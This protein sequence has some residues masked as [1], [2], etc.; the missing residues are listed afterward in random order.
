MVIFRRLKMRRRIYKLMATSDEVQSEG[1]PSEDWSMGRRSIIKKRGRSRFEY[2]HA[3]REE[4]RRKRP[5][6]IIGAVI[7]VLLAGVIGYAYISAFVIPPRNVILRVGDTVYTRGDVVD[8]IRFNQRVSEEAGVAFSPQFISTLSTL[9]EYELSYQAAPRFNITVH[10]DEVERNIAIIL[11]IV[12]VEQDE[13]S[14]AGYQA[15]LIE[16]KR[17]FLNKTGLSED[18]WRSFL[19]K[20]LFRDK[21]RDVISADIPRVQPH[22]FLYSIN[23]QFPPATETIRDINRSF[24]AGETV[25]QVA[26]K[27]S[28]DPD[29]ERYRGEV[30]WVP[31]GVLD[32]LDPILFGV[33][34]DGR[35]S[36]PLGQPSDVYFD[37]ETRRYNVYIISEYT[38]A[39]TISD[40][41]F[42]QLT[43]K[44]LTDFLI[45]E[46]RRR[47]DE[48]E[49]FSEFT[50][51]NEEWVSKQIQNSSLIPSPTPES[52]FAGFTER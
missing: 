31:A 50:S 2:L 37:S 43:E 38:E 42:Q 7:L 47:F 46:Q 51:A 23:F 45:A 39:R 33:E 22:I 12:P 17:Q 6:V 9:I 27:F 26:S 34:E 5:F 11:G 3:T 32:S 44:A 21:L 52:P 4:N 18:D 35:R 13:I 48:D 41:H 29:I 30:G 10:P 8:F 36:L 28:D 16:A 49:F 24:Q 1:V 15:D 14:T 40:D 25:E 20:A 19:Q